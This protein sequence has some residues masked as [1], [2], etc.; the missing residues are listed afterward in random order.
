MRCEGQSLDAAQCG[1]HCGEPS[2]THLDLGPGAQYGDVAAV[3]PRAEFG[4]EREIEK[5]VRS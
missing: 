3:S 5:M 2:A 1:A 4:D